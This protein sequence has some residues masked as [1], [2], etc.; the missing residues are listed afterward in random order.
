MNADQVAKLIKK[1]ADDV[2]I[3]GAR[4]VFATTDKERYLEALTAL[5]DNDLKHLTTITGVDRGEVIEIIYH[6]HCG[7]ALLNL[8]LALPK[9]DLEIETIT[10]IFPGAI[11][12]EREL[13][14][15]LGVQV[16]GHPDPRRLFLSDDWPIGKFPL[17]KEAEK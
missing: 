13:M 9:T 6:I 8:K 10:D 16:K 1:Y 2:K 14:E 17:R 11:L 7:E 15:M 5:R 12:Y 4:Q 3:V